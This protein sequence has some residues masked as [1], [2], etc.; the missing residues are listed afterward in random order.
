MK[1]IITILMI[2]VLMCSTV[3]AANLE[4]QKNEQGDLTV[5]QKAETASDVRQQLENKKQELLQEMAGLNIE[6]KK[7][8]QNQNEVRLAVHALLA[9]EDR[10][11]GIGKQVSAIAREFDNS[12]QSTINA[13]ERIAR[14]GSLARLFTGGDEEAADEIEKEVNKNKDRITMLRQLKDQCECG[15]DFKALFEEQI[16]N[17]EQE[18][19]R[20]IDLSKNEKSSKG[21]FGWFWK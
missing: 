9:M 13:E 15:S 17:L 2:L 14:K 3:L 11:G 10:I 16:A 21:L 12:V 4:V 5:R 1:S 18:Q 8:L 20:L 7:V 19:T 6:E